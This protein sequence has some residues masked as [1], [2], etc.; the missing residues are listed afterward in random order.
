[1]CGYISDNQ[2]LE[3]RLE[4]LEQQLSVN[5]S[6]N[7]YFDKKMKEQLELLEER[8]ADLEEQLIVTNDFR[9]VPQKNR[10]KLVADREKDSRGQ[11]VRKKN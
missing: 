5:E 9:Y 3:H 6:V 7:D 11:S 4:K 10:L 8:I 1:M 2:R